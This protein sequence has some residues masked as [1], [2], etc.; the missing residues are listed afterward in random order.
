MDA[1]IKQ[2]TDPEV[3]KKYVASENF[4]WNRRISI[5]GVYDGHVKD[6]TEK[7]AEALIKQGRTD[8]RK[9]EAGAAELGNAK[10]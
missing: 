1:Q 8:I 9:K 2:F 5:P 7:A 4:H 6:L 10:K 3:A